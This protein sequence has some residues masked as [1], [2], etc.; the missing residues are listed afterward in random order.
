LGFG[1]S[2]ILTVVACGVGI[3][4]LTGPVAWALYVPFLLVALYMTVRFRLFNAQPWRR[5]HARAM[6]AYG[7]LA[8]QEYDSAKEGGR[9]FDITAPCR[10][11]AAEQLP[12]IGSEEIEALLGSGRKR[13]YSQLVDAYP[14]VFLRG[15]GEARHP[16]VLESVR[17][18][19]EASDLGPDIVIA[20]VIERRHDRR[21]AAN[22]LHALLLGRVR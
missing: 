6:I 1:W 13:Y 11:F 2:S 22:Y 17:R 20:K 19:I 16:A 3:N 21:E 7:R 18:D 5:V 15:I 14:E 4:L 10:A 12:G 9:E 8:G